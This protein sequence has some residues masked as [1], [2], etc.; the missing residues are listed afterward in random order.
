MIE[1]KEDPIREERLAMEILVDAWGE[2]ERLLSWYY[3]LE[4]HLHLPFRAKSIKKLT[5]SPLEEGEEVTVVGMPSEDDWTDHA[6]VLIEWCGRTLGVPLEQL[7]A[8]DADEDTAEAIG[9]WHYWTHMGY[10]V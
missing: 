3:H 4:E 9:D 1:R 5:I 8:I 2:E 10:Q 7:I 6:P